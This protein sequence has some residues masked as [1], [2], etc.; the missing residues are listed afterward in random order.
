MNDLNHLLNNNRAWADGVRQHEPGFIDE[1][2]HL[3]TPQYQWSCRVLSNLKSV[4]KT[5]VAPGRN[6]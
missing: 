2:A 3:Q 1:L 4:R 5:Q 6:L